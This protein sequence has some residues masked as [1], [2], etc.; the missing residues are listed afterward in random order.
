[1]T[2]C[3]G[4]LP[5]F[6]AVFLVSSAAAA[7]DKDKA[8][9]YFEDGVSFYEKG[10]F[11]RAAYKLLRAYELHQ[12][13]KFLEYIGKTHVALEEY[14]KAI[15]AFKAYL[16]KGGGKI[17][18]KKRA[19]V[20]EELK[21]LEDRKRHHAQRSEALAHF[22]KGQELFGK[23]K[24]EQAI[25]EFEEAQE[26]SPSHE[27][28]EFIAKTEGALGNYERGVEAYRKY[29]KEGGDEISGAKRKK[30]KQEIEILRQLQK[31]VED[32]DE[33]RVHFEKG[34]SLLEKG[35]Y[36]KATAA[37]DQAY[38]LD[39]RFEMLEYIGQ[40][41]AG[42]KRYRKAILAY[43][44]FLDTGGQR[45]PPD[46]RD[47]VTVEIKR[48]LKLA[49]A[50]ANVGQSKDL[51]RRGRLSLKNKKYE[52]ALKQLEQAYEL[53]PRYQLF[54]LI[55][56]ANE[57]MK[58]YRQAITAYEHF[59]KEGSE[60]VSTKDRK[61]TE[62]RIEKLKGKI[63]EET[64]K[65]KAHAHYKLGKGYHAQGMFE[66]AVTEFEQA[67]EIDPS[68]EILT[69]LAESHYEL[70]EYRLAIET[71]EKYIDVGGK[72]LSSGQRS[73]A[74]HRIEQ[75]KALERGETPADA[76]ADPD[77]AEEDET[78]EDDTPEEADDEPFDPD[79]RKR[80]WTWIAGGVGVAAGIGAVATGVVGV[81]EQK[82]VDDACPSGQCPP[83]LLDSA[84][85]RQQTVDRLVITTNVL[86]GV[87]AV[88][89]AAGVTLFFLEPK[90][91]EP[92]NFSVTPAA[93]EDAAGIV[94]SGTF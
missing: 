19:S 35:D 93:S 90:H 74:R 6:L 25:I 34:K 68:P 53:D 14:D 10:Q 4:W 85:E 47:R 9:Q 18:G 59:L 79:P 70:K 24:F 3:R 77:E 48:L 31:K 40:A 39:A 78:E 23:R 11:E 81:T 33:A 38:F 60:S 12:S 30:A 37:L 65:A 61:A 82:K 44:T 83:E 17:P 13:W 58:R 80:F 94:V 57:K 5:G 86:I 2:A 26:L 55:G 50:D 1:M 72:E 29:L 63:G 42:G 43:R 27:F 62:D 41:H 92:P 64:V 45:V 89:V 36:D 69:H 71:Y 56:Q 15:S 91:I 87:A 67:F 73:D 28:L 32:K 84:N 76:D 52:K 51:E 7:D 88:G 49:T 22:K 21:K 8:E 54:A 20:K 16:R 46:V 75:L 66:K